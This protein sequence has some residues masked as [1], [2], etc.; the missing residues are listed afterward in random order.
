MLKPKSD[1]SFFVRG[2]SSEERDRGRAGVAFQAVNPRS[3]SKGF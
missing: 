3:G 1:L 2:I